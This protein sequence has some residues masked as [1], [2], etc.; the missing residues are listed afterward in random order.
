VFL[1]AGSFV[2]R[3]FKRPVSSIQSSPARRQILKLTILTLVFFI[4]FQSFIFKSFLI[5][6]MSM[7]PTLIRNDHIVV[8]RLGF[9][10]A[11]FGSYLGILKSYLP[12]EGDVVVFRVPFVDSAGNKKDRLMIKRIVGLPDDV[13]E[14][15]DLR[16]F[17]N[18]IKS[19]ERYLIHLKDEFDEFDKA[20]ALASGKISVPE[21]YGPLKLGPDQYF[22]L[23]DNRVDSQDSRVYW[24]ISFSQI[25]GKAWLVLG[26]FV[27]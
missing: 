10:L 16:V 5:P 4:I 2:T 14:V 11:R 15:R 7:Y 6:S 1:S 25:E 13:I 22:L 21:N 3:I 23:G 18:G 12:K 20:R 19:F 8:N 9:N 27:R 17:K 26:R 24:P